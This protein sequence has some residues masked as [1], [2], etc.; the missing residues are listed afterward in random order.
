MVMRL[1]RPRTVYDRMDDEVDEQR[2]RRGEEAASRGELPLP[3]A[4]GPREEPERGGRD[5]INGMLA[6]STSLK[7]DP[8][9][10]WWSETR[11]SRGRAASPCRGRTLASRRIRTRPGARRR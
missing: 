1:V 3:I 7:S 2:E 11:R 9:Q 8:T 10:W 5:T 4:A 6:F